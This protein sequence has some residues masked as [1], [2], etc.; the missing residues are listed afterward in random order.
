[1][2][3]TQQMSPSLLLLVFV[4][5]AKA[6]W[7][8]FRITGK[9]KID[10]RLFLFSQQQQTTVSEDNFDWQKSVS[11]YN[12][13]KLANGTYVC[14]QYFLSAQ[15]VCKDFGLGI[16]LVSGEST[17]SCSTDAG[18]SL[19]GSSQWPRYLYLHASEPSSRSNRNKVL[20][21][22]RTEQGGDGES[23]SW[24]GY[25]P[26]TPDATFEGRAEESSLFGTA[27]FNMTFSLP[28]LNKTKLICWMWAAPW[29]IASNPCVNVNPAARA[30]YFLRCNSTVTEEF[31][32]LMTMGGSMGRMEDR[33]LLA[34]VA[35]IVLS[36]SN[37]ATQNDGCQNWFIGKWF[38]VGGAIAA[39]GIVL[40]ALVF[41]VRERV[42]A[43]K[44]ASYYHRR[45]TDIL[46]LKPELTRLLD[47]SGQ[48]TSI[49]SS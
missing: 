36:M 18:L 15:H 31:M 11:F 12:M 3:S 47:D 28:L 39:V 7:I 19:S 46:P 30:W 2:K 41:I 43:W 44:E 35:T 4:L 8:D 10:F 13:T 42:K 17:L 5:I 32:S 9:V 45:P 34:P 40:F 1:M 23:A 26:D 6:N 20:S 37:L 38:L 49:N 14:G 21:M 48:P 22:D 24:S 29:D 25:F 27:A 33:C 16:S